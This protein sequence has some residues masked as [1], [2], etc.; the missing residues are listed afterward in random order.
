VRFVLK[1]AAAFVAVFPLSFSDG[2]IFCLV[3]SFRAAAI[4]SRRS[5]SASPAIAAT[6]S[7]ASTAKGEQGRN[8]GHMSYLFRHRQARRQG[9]KKGAPGFH[10]RRPLPFQTPAR[11][12]E[13]KARREFCF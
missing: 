10:A 5:F 8:L 11:P 6:M 3:S 13:Q 7:S 2:A 1:S 12:E 9:T 4:F